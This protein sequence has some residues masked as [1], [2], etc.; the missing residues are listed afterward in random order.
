MIKR[1]PSLFAS[2]VVLTFGY[3][4]TSAVFDD[5]PAVVSSTA[6]ERH[7]DARLAFS[8]ASAEAP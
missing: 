6:G 8:E 2:L 7:H 3:V 4:G 1:L 5:R